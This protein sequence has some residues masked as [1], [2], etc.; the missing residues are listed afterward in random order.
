METGNKRKL[1][2]IEEDNALIWKLAAKGLTTRDIALEVSAKRSYNISHSTIALAIR[3]Q[4]EKWKKTNAKQVDT[5]MTTE[6]AKIQHMESEAWTEYERS[7]RTIVELRKSDGQTTTI[8]REPASGNPKFLDVVIKCWERRAK[9]LSL[10]GA[11]KIEKKYDLSNLT[12]EQI[13][14]LSSL[15]ISNV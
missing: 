4:K 13:A 8:T 12:T 10:D 15:Q 11:V 2:Q 5:H 9:L 14:A 6:L 7:K 1:A 3:Q